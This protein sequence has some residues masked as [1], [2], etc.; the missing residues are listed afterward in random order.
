MGPVGPGD[1]RRAGW[2]IQRRG[3]VKHQIEI[4]DSGSAAARFAPITVLT[5]GRVGLRVEVHDHALA[6][7]VRLEEGIGDVL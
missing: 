6:A 4:G 3:I 5:T 1:E 7:K 2:N